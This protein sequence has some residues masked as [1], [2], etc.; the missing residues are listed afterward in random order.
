LFPFFTRN[1]EITERIKVSVIEID[2]LSN[3]AI[4]FID[5]YFV[6]ICE[7]KSTS[8]L[9]TVK[10]RVCNLFER[11]TESWRMGAT[12]EFFI[13]LFIVS[14][15]FRQECLY[16]NL[17]EGSIKK[18]FD[19]YYS[20]SEEEWLMES[21]SG[22]QNTA[23]ISHS[24]KIMEAMHD[25][26]IK[27]DGRTRNNPW[28]NAYSH[29]SHYD[30]GT[31]ED[32]RTGLRKMADDFTNGIYYS[33]DQF[34]TMPCSTIFLIGVREPNAIVDI[35]TEIEQLTPELRGLKVHVICINYRLLNMFLQYI[36]LLNA[37]E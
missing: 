2:D 31:S 3:E 37:G 34:N 26:E 20:R 35:I 19:G 32:I 16:L 22:S 1:E 15:G 10:R 12:A 33:I 5:K 25:L 11:K 23:N 6:S 24:G 14:S 29:A 28:Q 36:G 13:H 4:A 27:I 8:D 21:K 18:G 9:Q 17:E 30:V 7:G